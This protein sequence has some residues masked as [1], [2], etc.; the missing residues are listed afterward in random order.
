MVDQHGQIRT[1]V[2]ALRRL[3]FAALVVVALCCGYVGFAVYLRGSV[4]FGHDPIDLLYD[5]LQLFV[6]GPFPLQQGGGHYPL[7][8]QIGRLTAPAVTVY[9]FIEAGRLFLAAELRRMQIRRTRGHVVVCG[10]G[11]TATTL[12]DRL[13]S[14]GQRV[15][16]ILPSAPGDTNPG[17]H[18][19]HGDARMPDVLMAAGVNQASTLYAC[20]DD[21]ATNTVIALT[22]SRIVSESG[23]GLAVFAQVTDPELCLALQARHLGLIR[24][25]HLR[26][27]FF[28]I[29]ELAA[30]KL[31]AELPAAPVDGR[32]QHALV[33]G[34]S[35]FGRAVVV[36]L[37]RRWRI[38]PP[39]P[40][41]TPVVTLL[42]DRASAVAP[43]LGYRYQFLEQTCRLQAHDGGLAELLDGTD[44]DVRPTWIFVCYDDEEKCLKTALTV[45]RLWHGGR[46]SMVV[47]LDRMAGLRAAFDGSGGDA[48]LDE[49]SGVLRLF[50][51]IE[52]AC[53]PSLIRE[54]LVERV[55]RIIHDRYRITRLRRGD[56]PAQNPSM[57]DWEEL[58]MTLRRSSRAQAEDL[59]RKLGAIGCVLAPR[60]APG[61]EYSLTEN[62]IELLA[63]MEHR[64]WL[65]ERTGEGWLY[66]QH[67]RDAFRQHPDLRP[68][69][70]LSEDARDKN[71]DSVRELAAIVGDA[72]FRIVRL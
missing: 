26:L 5:T 71:R 53:D 19:V 48:L 42:D 32:P 60:V 34:A 69:D 7:A 57:V 12:A 59:G 20:T 31:F 67:R 62:S 13:R 65:E 68:W 44:S 52:A 30:R 17:R 1:Q 27:G 58:P 35:A 54:D 61:E 16:S 18:R 70:R 24:P 3:I 72:G 4:H 55:A 50:G 56:I 33:I 43:E 51:V 6:L 21:T 22:A 28:N 46:G 23:P 8:L 25:L 36:E 39:D 45:D 9:A 29:D 14:S 64:R 66:S 49:V 41:N 47:R 11:S 37:A 38:A 40:A 15:V 10:T 2:L 63:E